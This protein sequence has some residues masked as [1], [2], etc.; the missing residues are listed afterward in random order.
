MIGPVAG[1]ETGIGLKCGTL[2]P[3]LTLVN[4]EIA[5]GLNTDL[6]AQ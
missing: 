6:T 1:T 5:C 2:E 3:S 4:K